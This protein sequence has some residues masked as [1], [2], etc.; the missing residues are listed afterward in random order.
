MVPGRIWGYLLPMRRLVTP[1]LFCKAVGS[2]VSATN[3]HFM[4][5]MFGFMNSSKHRTSESLKTRLSLQSLTGFGIIQSLVILKY[6][7]FVFFF[8]CQLKLWIRKNV[9]GKYCVT[10]KNVTG[11]YC[12]TVLLYWPLCGSQVKTI[13]SKHTKSMAAQKIAKSKY[14]RMLES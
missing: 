5:R 2:R 8:V 10:V 9:T 11:Q 12:V 14:V 13:Q 1:E 3:S 7:L 6:E 4:L